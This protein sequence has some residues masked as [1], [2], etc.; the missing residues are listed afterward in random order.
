MAYSSIYKT[1]TV[2]SVLVVLLFSNTSFCMKKK[3]VKSQSARSVLNREYTNPAPDLHKEASKQFPK[4]GKSFINAIFTHISTSR[5]KRRKEK[6]ELAKF[7]FSFEENFAAE[8]ESD[9]EDSLSTSSNEE[10]YI[11]DNW[12]KESDEVYN[13]IQKLSSKKCKEFELESA[14]DKKQKIK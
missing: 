14:V 10:H 8:F 3:E 11:E 9:D 7:S 1:T 13:F 6:R 4:I 5:S 12:V 2:V